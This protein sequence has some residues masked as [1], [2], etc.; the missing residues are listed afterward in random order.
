MQKSPLKL[1]VWTMRFAS[2]RSG[3]L[4]G[5]LKKFAQFSPDFIAEG[6]GDQAP[7]HREAL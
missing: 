3:S 4:A 2:V 7:A 5:L 1:R 6:R